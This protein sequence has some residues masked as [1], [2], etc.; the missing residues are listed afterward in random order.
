MIFIELSSFPNLLNLLSLS[1]SLVPSLPVEKIQPTLYFFTEFQFSHLS[2]WKK[3]HEIFA[4][5]FVSKLLS[6][7]LFEYSNQLSMCTKMK[8]LLSK[9]VSPP[10]IFSSNPLLC[11]PLN[12]LSCPFPTTIVAVRQ[13][14]K[15]TLVQFLLHMNHQNAFFIGQ[16]YINLTIRYNLLAIPK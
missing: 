16:Y 3:F 1:S 2:T 14:Y 7:L 5:Q 11:H 12:Y 10:P 4:H 9:G 6:R 8:C 13:F 15:D